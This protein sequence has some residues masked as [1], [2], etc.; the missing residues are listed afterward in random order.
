MSIFHYL[1][2]KLYPIIRFIYERVQG[3]RWYDHIVDEVW[4]GGAPTYARDYDYL[5]ENGIGAV[6]DIRNERSDDLDHYKRHDIRHLKLRVPD[7]HVPSADVISAGVDFIQEQIEDG[8][9]VYVHCAKGRGRS[10]TLI[11]GWLMKYKNISFEEARDFMVS[12]RKLVKLEHRHGE[13]LKAWLNAQSMH[14]E[15]QREDI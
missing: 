5:I 7:I 10:A 14:P 3:N 13:G 11:A 1:F 4:L 6:I 8:R 2:D 12:K 15:P 9:Q